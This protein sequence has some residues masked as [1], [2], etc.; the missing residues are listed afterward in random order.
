MNTHMLLCNKYSQFII[1][2]NFDN[3]T[4]SSEHFKVFK[5]LMRNEN[6]L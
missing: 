5:H 1:F 6:I 4:E 3:D 2:K